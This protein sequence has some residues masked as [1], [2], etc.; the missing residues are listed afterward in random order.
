MRLIDLIYIN[1]GWILSNIEPFIIMS[2]HPHTH[3]NTHCSVVGPVGILIQLLLGILSFSVLIIKRH[4][5]NPKRPWRV[6]RYDTIKQ[7]ISQMLAHFLNLTISMALTS[8]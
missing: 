5:E 3:S 7:V 1:F 4:F 6:W 2:R 8:E